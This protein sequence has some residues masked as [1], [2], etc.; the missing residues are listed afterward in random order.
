MLMSAAMAARLGLH[1]HQGHASRLR[2]LKSSV[3]LYSSSVLAFQ[4]RQQDK[5]NR[6]RRVP[7]RMRVFF[8][9]GLI[10][11]FGTRALYALLYHSSIPVDNGPSHSVEI[12]VD[13]GDSHSVPQLEIVSGMAISQQLIGNRLPDL[14]ETY[15]APFTAETPHSNRGKLVSG[16]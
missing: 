10:S 12:A 6:S 9:C 3:F 16:V 5:Q 2:L 15:N 13:N 8:R 11:D 1:L 14:A 4:T 7:A